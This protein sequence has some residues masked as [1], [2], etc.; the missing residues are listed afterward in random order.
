RAV[1][2]GH[3][4]AVTSA[5]FSP[6]GKRILTAC[7]AS[8]R[9][10]DVEPA[11]LCRVLPGPHRPLHSLAYSADGRRLLTA[12]TNEGA[13]LWDPDTGAE[14]WTL[15]RGRELGPLRSAHFSGDGRRVVMASA[16]ARVTDRGKVVN[17]GPVHLW[18]AATGAELLAL[19]DHGGG[20]R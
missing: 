6:D 10:W 2:R 3:P 5:V 13:R 11:P 16:H 8:V 14:V 9:L 19:Q 15:G 4:G 7:D 17:A 1:L 18:D 12:G 20:A